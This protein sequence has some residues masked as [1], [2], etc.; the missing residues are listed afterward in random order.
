MRRQALLS[1][2][3]QIIHLWSQD[4]IVDSF[5]L[6]KNWYSRTRDIVCFTPHIFFLIIILK[7][8]ITHSASHSL[9]Y[10]ADAPSSEAT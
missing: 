4:Y 9:S 10:I 8:Y 6:M 2:V 3:N 1:V 5:F 7:P